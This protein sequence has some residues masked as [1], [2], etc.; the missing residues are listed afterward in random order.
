VRAVTALLSR[1]S[2]ESEAAAERMTRS[3]ALSMCAEGSFKEHIGSIHDLN[4]GLLSLIGQSVPGALE[5]QVSGAFKTVSSR[6][7]KP[8]AGIRHIHSEYTEPG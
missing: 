2:E 3:S 4:L 8:F 5:E 7:A 6:S 1:R